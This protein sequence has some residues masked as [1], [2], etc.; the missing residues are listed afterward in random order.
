MCISNHC[1]DVYLTVCVRFNF[2]SDK[3]IS[4]KLSA[5]LCSVAM[6]R[7]NQLSPNYHPA[8]I[9]LLKSNFNQWT[10]GVLWNSHKPTMITNLFSFQHQQCKHWTK[11]VQCS[12]CWPWIW[13][14][15][16][17][18]NSVFCLVE[19]CDLSIMHQCLQRWSKWIT[20]IPQ[21]AF[22]SFR[23][24]R[25][26]P[27]WL[28]KAPDPEKPENRSKI[29]F[30]QEKNQNGP[31]TCPKTDFCAIWRWLAKLWKN[32]FP[33]TFCFSLVETRAKSNLNKNNS[34]KLSVTLCTAAMDCMFQLSLIYHPVWNVHLVSD[35]TQWTCWV[36]WSSHKQTMIINLFKFLDGFKMPP[37]TKCQK[38]VPKRRSHKRKINTGRWP[39]QNPIFLRFRNESQK[40]AKNCI[41]ERF[42]LIFGRK[43]YTG[44]VFTPKWFQNAPD[45]ELSKNRPKTAFP[46]E[47][48]QY[49]P[50]T[51]PKSDFFAF[52]QRIAKM[53][54]KLYFWTL[55]V[56]F[57]WKNVHWWCF[58]A[59]REPQ[60]Y[61][62][63]H[64]QMG[65]T[66]YPASVGTIYINVVQHFPLACASIQLVLREESS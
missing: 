62:I 8:W 59:W 63:W 18:R 10:F 41:F 21:S 56:D 15:I 52:F 51:C 58:Y 11:F 64:Y 36:H 16:S 20:T 22:Y 26:S 9:V 7:I 1:V 29:A 14:A 37:T 66:C 4:N 48:N 40:C 17:V 2:N 24:P 32:L 57:W 27:K 30:P 12:Q 33:A 61:R 23:V 49:G 3:T 35:F 50:V 6:E 53:C 25:C 19:L 39:A 65:G 54:K 44:G 45:H 31:A 38:I 42:S 46:Q 43:T 47:K 55:F 28:Q 60:P 5:A 13:F 34:N